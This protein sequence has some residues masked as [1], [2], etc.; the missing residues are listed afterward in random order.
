M[1][2]RSDLLEALGFLA[3]GKVRSKICTFPFE[4]INDVIKDLRQSAFT[5]RAVLVFDNAT[6]SQAG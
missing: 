2:T 5:G 6:V 1:G 4:K 3:R